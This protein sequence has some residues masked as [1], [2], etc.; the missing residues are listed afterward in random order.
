MNDTEVITAVTEPFA[1]VH[2]TAP[3]GTVVR[4]GRVL[5]RR[6]RLPGLA[7]AAALAAGLAL[8]VT[9]LLPGGGAAPARAAAWSVTLRPNGAVAVTI[10][11]LRDPARLQQKLRADGV[12]ANVSV[13]KGR[14]GPGNGYVFNWKVPS[15]YVYGIGSGTRYPM[16]LWR[17]IFYGQHKRPTGWT[18]WIHP[19][20]IPPGLG[21]AVQA[22]WAGPHGIAGLALDLVKASPQCT[23][24]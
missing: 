19:S 6:R 7:G 23:G 21:I 11:Q 20:A 15:C 24:S 22:D 4:R 12:P 5:R 2:M 17:K 1:G 14:R 8:A 3:L 10:R 18:F 13:Q 9:A 16:S